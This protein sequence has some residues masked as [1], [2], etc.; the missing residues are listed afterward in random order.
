MPTFAQSSIAVT[1]TLLRRVSPRACQSLLSRVAFVGCL[2]LP[3]GCGSAGSFVWIDDAP[4]ATIRSIPE[5]LILPGDMVSV[6]VFGQE[7]MSVRAPVRSDGVIAMPLI[8]DVQMAGKT[9]TSIAKDIEGRLQPFI[10]TPHVTVV[11]E[12]S[13]TRVVVIGEVRRPGTV[14][15]EGSMGMLAAL[16]N[17][18]G[19]T[20]YASEDRI[21]VL[22]SD[23]TG[24][25]RI[26]FR[27]E[28][29]IRNIGRAPAFKLRTGDVVVV[30]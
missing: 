4:E 17:A 11:V 20:E 18:G 1:A 29:T 21:F 5:T 22:R 2:M 23:T 27:Y 25:Y 6:R 24:L 3:A 7:P 9:A 26:R 13:R 8:G 19:L 28:D 14:I 16:A 15:L 10:N 12:E 30:E